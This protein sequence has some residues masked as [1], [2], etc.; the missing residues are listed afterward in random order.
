MKV[1]KNGIKGFTEQESFDHMVPT[2]KQKKNDHL[3]PGYDT[4]PVLASGFKQKTRAQRKN[5]AKWDKNKR[6]AML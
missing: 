4:I 3:G 2:I 5:N 1:L 6:I